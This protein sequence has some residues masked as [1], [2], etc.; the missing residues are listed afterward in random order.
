MFFSNF[1]FL[2]FALISPTVMPGVSSINIPADSAI[3]PD[4]TAIFCQSLS[5]RFPF[6]KSLLSTIACEHR[7]LCAHC[8]FDISNENITTGTLALIATFVAIFRANADLPIAGLAANSINSV[9]FNPDNNSSKSGYPVD[10]PLIF[11]SFAD[12]LL[13]SSNELLK[14]FE[15]SS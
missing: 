15:I 11:A 7:I 1:N 5:C 6:S 4:A 13:I 2:H 10:V 8:S 12:N 9:F 3:S 14:I